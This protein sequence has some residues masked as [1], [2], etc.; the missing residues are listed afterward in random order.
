MSDQVLRGICCFCSVL[1]IYYTDIYKSLTQYFCVVPH[2]LVSQPIQ[3]LIEQDILWAF[4]NTS[5]FLPNY[6]TQ[7]SL[8]LV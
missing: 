6:T 4:R 8:L 7:L 2:F 3:T 5:V 1:C